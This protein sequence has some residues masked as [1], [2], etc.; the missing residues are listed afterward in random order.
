[1]SD[2]DKEAEREKLRQQYERDKEERKSTQRM[3]ELLLQ[4][5][6]MTGKHCDNC[7]DPIFRQNGTEFCPTCR[8]E[9][10]GEASSEG[11]T[12]EA[13]TEIEV[14]RTES[15]PEP[16][17]R[18]DEPEQPSEQAPRPRQPGHAPPSRTEASRERGREARRSEPRT[19][20]DRGESGDASDLTEARNALRRKLTR[21]A[22][23]AERT[24][25]VGYAR[26]LLAATR[27]A[28]EALA[29]LDRAK[30]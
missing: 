12:S 2:F 4:G 22:H 28:A 20:A 1:M 16:S 15:E 18:S 3:S 14:E 7:G 13:A 17:T 8:G 5:A 26:E 11:T 27:E 6:T 30:R 19:D 25:D 21:L 9:A 10:A 23:E 24:D 29:A